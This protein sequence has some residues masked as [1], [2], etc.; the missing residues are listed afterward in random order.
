MLEVVR[1]SISGNVA[2][3]VNLESFNSHDI[4]II[5]IFIHRLTKL[6]YAAAII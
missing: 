4:C 1:S 2:E 5:I 6:Q 3:K